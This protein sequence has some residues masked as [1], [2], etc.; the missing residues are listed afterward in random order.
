M[1]TMILLY[2]VFYILLYYS[3]LNKKAGIPMLEELY[4]ST[5]LRLNSSLDNSQQRSIDSFLLTVIDR[6]NS[7]EAKDSL[8]PIKSP[9]EPIGKTI[10]CLLEQHGLYCTLYDNI[11]FVNLNQ[12]PN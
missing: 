12:K 10:Q 5:A 6:I 7:S 9:S 4:K 1:E 11:L 2:C 8:I 3:F